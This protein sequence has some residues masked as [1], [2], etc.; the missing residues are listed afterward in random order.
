MEDRGLDQL[1]SALDF[2]RIAAA[3]L[4]RDPYPFVIVEGAIRADFA[5]ALDAELP[6]VNQGG[7]H[8]L[9]E[10]EHGPLFD[11]L[12]AD[13]ESDC[14]RKLI[15]EK[16]GLELDGR[17]VLTTYR[18]WVR[19]KDGLTHTDTPNKAMTTLLYLNP[20]GAAD[21]A[22]LRI[23]RSGNLDD[24]VAEVPPRMGNMIIF[25]V[26]ANCWHGHK[27]MEGPRR[28]LQMNY[29]SGLNL[30]RHEY[31]GRLLRRLKRLFA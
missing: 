15:E 10:V 9:A 22:A 19:W 29:R 4:Q 2:D 17:D 30:K 8:A 23:L 11:R 20:P 24:Y 16:F 3:P 7:A 27:Q 28:S 14:F 21:T 6:E 25:Q 18:G 5:E 12:V 1:T 13:L 26:T 31:G